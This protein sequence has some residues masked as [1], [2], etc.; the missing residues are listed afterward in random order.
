MCWVQLLTSTIQ[1]LCISISETLSHVTLKRRAEISSDTS[2][3]LL[4]YF[5][6]SCK[7]FTIVSNIYVSYPVDFHCYPITFKS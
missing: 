6:L 2:A 7:N 3:R 1:F 4:R 5:R